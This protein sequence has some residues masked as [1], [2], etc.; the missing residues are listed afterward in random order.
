MARVATLQNDVRRIE[1][2][3]ICDQ[4]QAS[5]VAGELKQMLDLIKDESFLLSLTGSGLDG[6]AF[7]CNDGAQ[8][9]RAN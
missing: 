9:F 3:K 1:P 6:L 7:E 5:N 4:S 2:Q 8:D